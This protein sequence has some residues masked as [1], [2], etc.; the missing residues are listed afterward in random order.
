MTGK[1]HQSSLIPYETEIINL[2]HRRPP[3]PCTKIA[4]LLNEKYNLTV[5]ASAIFKFIKVRSRGRKVYSYGRNVQSERPAAAPKPPGSQ[6]KS[7]W[8]FKYSE[9]YNLTRLPSE[10]AESR[11]KK[12]EE[13]GH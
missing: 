3:V 2:R 4:E 9:R 11:R 13:E 12:L 1:P 8:N 6:T 7:N 5:Q 10:V